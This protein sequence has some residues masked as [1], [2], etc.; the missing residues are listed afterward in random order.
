MIGRSRTT[1]VPC[2]VRI[3]SSLTSLE[4][5]VEL[6][7][8]E[9]GPGDRVLVQD[10]PS[11]PGPRGHRFCRRRATVRHAGFAR[12]AWTRWL[13]VLELGELYEVGFSSRRTP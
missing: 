1:D 5:H 12:R 7:G 2:T 10:A 3:E 4:A 11:E 9:V 13:A 8:V 6:Q